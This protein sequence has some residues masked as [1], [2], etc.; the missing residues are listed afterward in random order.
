MNPSRRRYSRGFKL[1][2]IRRVQETGRSQAEVVKELG[3][4]ANTLS[5][6]K[7]QYQAEQKEA[8]PGQTR[9]SV[10]C[11]NSLFFNADRVSRRHRLVEWAGRYVIYCNQLI[12]WF[13][14]TAEHR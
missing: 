1:E 5:R 10:E 9:Q 4:S 7:H 2:I 8:L 12:A 3:V 6:W 13:N 11:V 14:F